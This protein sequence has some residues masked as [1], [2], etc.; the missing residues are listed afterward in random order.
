MLGLSI[1]CWPLL[2][3]LADCTS[4]ACQAL[5]A[6][7]FPFHMIV[8]S[9]STILHCG[10]SLKK[11]LPC[12]Q[13]ANRRLFDCFTMQQPVGVLDMSDVSQLPGRLCVLRSIEKPSLLLRGQVVK[14]TNSGSIV[15]LVEPW[16]NDVSTL[17]ATGLSLDDFPLHSPI[18]DYLELVESQQSALRDSH[19]LS[20]EL[21]VLNLEL[22]ERVQRRTQALEKNTQALLESKQILE[23][24][25]NER[26]RV[27]IELRHAHKLEA[28]GQLAA[29]IAH[30]INTPMQFIGSSVQFLKNAFKNLAE[31][32]EH[33]ENC[34]ALIEG[35]DNDV[36]RFNKILQ[37][38]DLDYVRDRVPKAIDRTLE[39]ITRVSQIVGA[40]NEFSHPD[41]QEK[42]PTDINR[43]LDT[44]II[45]A[46]N[47]YKYVAT[48]EKRFETI[49]DID[50]HLGDLNQVFLNLIIN[51]AHAISE[52]GNERGLIVVSTAQE[53]DFV[54]I[55][56]SDSGAG[57]PKAVQHRIFDPFFT[58]KE[59]GRGT[60]QGLAI[61][62]KI[63]V[64][65]H[66][67]QLSF[68]SVV[69]QGTTFHVVL[70]ICAASLSE[71]RSLNAITRDLAA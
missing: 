1:R 28:V 39:G 69:G 59:V 61:S 42:S 40:M 8:C 19:R 7:A 20:E 52:K 68:D 57:I 58:T 26:E 23:Q 33:L 25:M 12:T 36:A 65:N 22:E 55:S 11:V 34:V 43:A 3:D 2:M 21:G 30:E 64:E 16:V 41:K 45:V 17:R 44:T 47:E 6:V 54:K 66:G 29:G 14:T 50:G 60:G 63:V 51:A 4:G 10:D 48:L 32:S 5:L 56:I 15:F 27:E 49:P 24:E 38:A 35:H 31:V 37:D 67:G 46:T 53:G 62:H 71:K 13:D 9:E 18:N 70:P